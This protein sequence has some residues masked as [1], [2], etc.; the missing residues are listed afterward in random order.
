[1]RNIFSSLG[2]Y[3]RNSGAKKR[4]RKEKQKRSLRNNLVENIAVRYIVGGIRVE[5]L[6]GVTYKSCNMLKYVYLQRHK[7]LQRE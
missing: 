5:W 2:N 1:M 3:Y 6:S 7:R 4:K